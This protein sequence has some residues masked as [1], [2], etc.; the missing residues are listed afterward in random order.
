MP[1]TAISQ[2]Q[3]SPSTPA[4]GN[5]RRNDSF[6]AKRLWAEVTIPPIG[7]LRFGRMGNHWGLGMYQNDGNCL[8]CDYGNTVDRIMLVL[9]IANHYIIPMMDWVGAGALSNTFSGDQ[10]GQPVSFDRLLEAYQYGIQIARRDSDEELKTLAEQGK[11]SFNYGFYGTIR[12]Q[13]HDLVAL[14]GTGGYGQVTPNGTSWNAQTTAG[15]T[16]LRRQIPTAPTFN[17][18]TPD[19]WRLPGVDARGAAFYVP[20]VWARL[21]TRRLRLE[22]EL[23]YVNG[24]YNINAEQTNTGT[25]NGVT[26]EPNTITHKI[27]ESSFGGA[28]QGEYKFLSDLQLSVGF[29]MGLATGNHSY[30][31]GVQLTAHTSPSGGRPP[32]DRSTAIRSTAPTPLNPACAAPST[33]SASAPITGSTRS[34]GGR[35]WARSPMLS[36]SSPP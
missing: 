11:L 14:N 23:V 33:P 25:A 28:F 18:P 34:S 12:N 27:S 19:I 26:F 15:P 35:S 32:G 13:D 20:D 3:V 1:Y 17:I 4:P 9:K 29:D 5:R 16:R 22:T 10:L 21:K 30:G 36:S 24:S 2:S 31:F 7:Q 8:D 6:R